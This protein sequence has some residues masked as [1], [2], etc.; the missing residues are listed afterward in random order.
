MRTLIVPQVQLKKW[1]RLSHVIQEAQSV[2]PDAKP[3]KCR[4][5][6]TSVNTLALVE[7]RSNKWSILTENDKKTINKEISRSVRSDYRTFVENVVCDLEK[8]NS[9]GNSSQVYKLAKSL[10]PS[11]KGNSFCQPSKDSAGNPITSNEQQLEEWAKFLE[12]KFAARP[13]KPEVDLNNLNGEEDPP[14]IS[15]EEVTN[16]VKC[17][18]KNKACGPDGVPIE[19]YKSSEVACKDVDD[20]QIQENLVLGEMLMMYK[21]KCKDDRSN[22][23]ALGLLNHGYKILEVILLRRIVIYIDPKLSEMQ[24][25]FRAGR[26]C[27]D[28]ILILNMVINHDFNNK[29]NENHLQS[30]GIITYI[31]FIAAFDSILHSYLLSALK[32]YGVPS[33]YCRLIQEIYK[34]AAVHVRI[35][36]PDGNKS[37]SRSIAIR[38]GMLQGDIPSPQ[39][40]IVALDK[41]IKEHGGAGISPNIG[42]KVTDNL[43]LIYLEFAGNATITASQRLTN[44]DEKGK[45]IAGMSISIPK[46]KC[47]HIMKKPKV[48]A[49][50]EKDIANLPPNLQFSHK[51]DKCDRSFSRKHGLSVHKGRWCKGKRR[52]K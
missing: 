47:Q 28:N 46:T 17:L 36:Q 45:T 30:L 7:E 9:V 23:R 40:F 38:R 41:L 31:D 10:K 3:I 14:I 13:N 26:G 27:R 1:E 6:E 25:G 11:G 18:K 48:T 20:E 39:G 19:Q 52:K 44:L 32:E 4:R 22:Y 5:W 12:V 8:A 49:T 33:K 37:Y 24:S 16:A 35:M 43:Q 42:L 29:D 51:C 50:T 2:L 21:K 34:T 15:F